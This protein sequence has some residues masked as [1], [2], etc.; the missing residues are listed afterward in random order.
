MDLPLQQFM[1]N[2]TRYRITF[3]NAMR[4]AE[5]IVNTIR[6]DCIHKTDEDDPCRCTGYIVG[7][8]QSTCG[9]CGHVLDDHPPRY[10]LSDVQNMV[11]EYYK[12]ELSIVI[13]GHGCDLSHLLFDQ[14]ESNLFKQSIVPRIKIVSAVPHSCLHYKVSQGYG[15]MYLKVIHDVYR[16][17]SL[18]QPVQLQQTQDTIRSIV[19]KAQRNPAMI[20]E[21]ERIATTGAANGA[22]NQFMALQPDELFH[23]HK[24]TVNRSYQFIPNKYDTSDHES[25]GI[26]IIASTLPDDDIE[27]TYSDKETIL[28]QRNNILSPEV[29]PSLRKY[30]DRIKEILSPHKK[31]EVLTLQ[32]LLY[33]L[34][35]IASWK[36]IRI[37]DLGCRETCFPTPTP[38][39]SP[40]TIIQMEREPIEFGKKN[41]KK[42]KRNTKSKKITISKK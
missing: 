38:I 22:A 29:S 35:T 36:T 4:E 14:P 10:E 6:H 5:R 32:D 20:K 9:S 41:K 27:F 30:K 23:L 3:P 17:Q 33:C 11:T 13:Y 31:I 39:L 21:Q 12:P 26:Y 8:D 34:Y 19:V 28:S 37:I 7:I 40:N 2:L 15:N 18:K 25:F 42:T 24:A 16:D 1:E